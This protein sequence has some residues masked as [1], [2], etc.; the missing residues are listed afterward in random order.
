MPGRLRSATAIADQPARKRWSKRRWDD[1]FLSRE[2]RHP[3]AM[4]VP[5]SAPVE[6]DGQAPHDLELAIQFHEDRWICHLPPLVALERQL[7][8][9]L[10]EGL[11]RLEPSQLDVL[12]LVVSKRSIASRQLSDAIPQFGPERRCAEAGFTKERKVMLRVISSISS[13]VTADSLVRD[14]S[15]RMAG[16]ATWQVPHDCRRLRSAATKRRGTGA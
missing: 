3:R 4:R 6:K 13:K 9:Q 16:W 2:Q 8:I 7:S 5:A 11:R 1:V 12:T 14:K 10:A 15:I